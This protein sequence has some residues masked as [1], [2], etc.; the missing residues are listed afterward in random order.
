MM[1]WLVLSA[2]DASKT[3]V[4]KDE[5]RCYDALF[6][7]DADASKMLFKEEPRLP[8]LEWP[9]HKHRKRNNKKNLEWLSLPHE[10]AD[11]LV[12]RVCFVVHYELFGF[13]IV[14]DTA[15]RTAASLF[16]E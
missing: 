11:H 5:P 15:R 9:S 6:Y 3:V 16:S 8:T 13:Q 1:M 4:Q 2:S 7:N 12:T 10:Q 14:A